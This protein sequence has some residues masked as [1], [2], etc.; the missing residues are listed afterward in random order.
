V[1]V[2]VLVFNAIWFSVPLV[3]FVVAGRHAA[4]ANA[5]ISQIN[6]WARAREQVI[7]IAVLGSVGAYLVVK[8]IAGLLS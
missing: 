4:A 6:A 7:L 8:G 5:K 2:G 1:I 3:S